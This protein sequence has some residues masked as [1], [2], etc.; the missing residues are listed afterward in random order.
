MVDISSAVLLR[1]ILTHYLKFGGVLF[2]TSNKRPSEV[3]AKG[4]GQKNL[5]DFLYALERRCENLQVDNEIDYRFANSSYENNRSWFIN[6]RMGFEEEKTKSLSESPIKSK[7]LNIYNRPFEINICNETVA[8][9][10][11]DDICDK[12][13]GPS[14]YLALT[15]TF[16]TIII[17]NVKVLTLH[18]KNQARRFITVSFNLYREVIYNNNNNRIHVANRCDL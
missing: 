10:T 15:S 16:H 1:D 11:F 13:L 6:D 9:F 14:D 18:Q 8:Y 17:D 5:S 3:Y 12:A 7:V 4:V 2:L